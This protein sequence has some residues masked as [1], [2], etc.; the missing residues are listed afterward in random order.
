MRVCRSDGLQASRLCQHEVLDCLH[1]Y[2]E[3]DT[4]GSCEDP[5]QSGQEKPLFSRVELIIG[6]GVEESSHGTRLRAASEG[7][8]AGRQDL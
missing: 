1:E 3:Y 8:G 4:P 6:R 2:L 5:H 7:T